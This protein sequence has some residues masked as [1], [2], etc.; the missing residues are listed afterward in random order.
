MKYRVINTAE[1]KLC[2]SFLALWYNRI[3]LLV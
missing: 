2:L 3:D 1:I